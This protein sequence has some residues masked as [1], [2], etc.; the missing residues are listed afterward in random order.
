ME[1]LGDGSDSPSSQLA[2]N[3]CI[4]TCWVSSLPMNILCH[5]QGRRCWSITFLW[6]SHPW[7]CSRPSWMHLGATWSA[8]WCPCA[9]QLRGPFQLLMFSIELFSLEFRECLSCTFSTSKARNKALLCPSSSSST[10]GLKRKVLLQEFLPG[11]GAR[12]FSIC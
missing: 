4:I 9:W 8:G 2:H 11:S 5:H 7:K 12:A 6:L 3:C 10:D 1:L